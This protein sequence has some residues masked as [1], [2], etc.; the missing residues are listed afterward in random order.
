VTVLG[1]R[2]DELDVDR[3]E[4]RAAGRGHKGLA[5]RDGALLAACNASLEQQPVLIDHTVVREAAH[6]GD[7][8]L[9]QV[10]LSGRTGLLVLLADLEDA[11]VDVGTMVVTHLAGTRTG[12]ADTRRMPSSDTG[13]LAQTS[14]GLTRQTSNSPTRHHT[15]ET[16]TL[17]DCAD[18]DD[19]ALHKH[20]AHWHFLFEQLLTPVYFLSNTGTTVDLDL[21]QVGNLAT[22]S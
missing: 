2:V 13:D 10:V 19:L 1:R 12:D 17:G 4:V 8:L 21:E 9:G 18:V 7:A 3:L 6:W 5:Q 15:H 22:K 14:V 16:L 11:L 20:V